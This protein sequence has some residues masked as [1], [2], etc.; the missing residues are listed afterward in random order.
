MCKYAYRGKNTRNS[1]N[2]Y[3]IY[4]RDEKEA[5]SNNLFILAALFAL[6]IKQIYFKSTKNIERKSNESDI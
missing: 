6:E 3:K 1:Y 5:K 4:E 2:S